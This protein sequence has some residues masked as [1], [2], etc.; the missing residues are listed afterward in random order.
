MMKYLATRIKKV[1]GKFKI[2]ANKNICLDE[3]ICSRIKA[4]SFRCGRSHMNEL[5]S[6]SKSHSKTINN[7][8]Y[9]NCTFVGDY[10]KVCDKQSIK[11]FYHEMYLQK[12]RKTTPSAFYEKRRFKNEIERIHLS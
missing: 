2:E 12:V 7:E 9:Y 3:F 1:V 11:S 8:D 6:L 4:F 5:K 10:Q